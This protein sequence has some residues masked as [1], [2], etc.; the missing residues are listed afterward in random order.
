MRAV[1]SPRRNMI[2]YGPEFFL[3]SREFHYMARSPAEALDCKG[4]VR[5][6]MQNDDRGIGSCEPRK[7][8]QRNLDV[9]TGV[10]KAN[11]ALGD[12]RAYVAYR[13]IFS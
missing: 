2:Q 9:A 6:R 13:R 5:K 8:A 7:Q 1:V 12:Q 11:L 3:F 10:Q 4:G